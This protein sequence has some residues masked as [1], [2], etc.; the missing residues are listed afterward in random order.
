M[1]KIKE[2]KELYKEIEKYLKKKQVT[3]KGYF[4]VIRKN[5]QWPR[6]FSKLSFHIASRSPRPDMKGRDKKPESINRG[7]DKVNQSSKTQLKIK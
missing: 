4:I 6:V 7:F 2:E 5:Y 1:A 3:K